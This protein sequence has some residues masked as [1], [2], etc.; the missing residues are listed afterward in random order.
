MKIKSIEK[1]SAR[2]QQLSAQAQKL[3]ALFFDTTPIIAG[4]F[5]EV[6]RQCGNPNCHCATKGQGHAVWTLL[7]K[8]NSK[9][10]C[11]VVR[12]ADVEAVGVKVQRYQQLRNALR[13]LKDIDIKKYRLLKEVIAARIQCYK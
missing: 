3:A 6:K 5:S 11:Q 4:T 8:H 12:K 9:R 13:Q 7:T 1:K 2:A 10:R